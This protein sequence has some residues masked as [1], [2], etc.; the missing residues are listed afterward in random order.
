MP[1]PLPPG[2]CGVWVRHQ[3]EI[4]CRCRRWRPA[5]RLASQAIGVRTNFGC[6]CRWRVRCAT[7][8][9]REIAAAGG[10]CVRWRIVAGVRCGAAV[11]W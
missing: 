1:P 6:C 5:T 2:R 8:S 10:D 4:V 3:R 11:G 7:R 9:R